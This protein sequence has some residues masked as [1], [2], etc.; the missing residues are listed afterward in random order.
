[1][2]K[3]NYLSQN[4][5]SLPEFEPETSGFV[6]FVAFTPLSFRVC[7]LMM[8]IICVQVQLDM[9]KHVDGGCK[10]FQKL[11]DE[12]IVAFLDKYVKS[13]TEAALMLAGVDPPEFPLDTVRYKRCPRNQHS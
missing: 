7:A 5:Y 2:S 11:G 10:P 4:P 12:N 13:N 9:C 3:C 1:V 8:S 6:P